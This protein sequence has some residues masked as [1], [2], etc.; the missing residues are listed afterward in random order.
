MILHL[1]INMWKSSIC[2]KNKP[3]GLFPMHMMVFIIAILVNSKQ[4][5]KLSFLL[6]FKDKI[7]VL[8]IYPIVEYMGMLLS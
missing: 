2:L 1:E 5:R 7:L 6:T 4:L 8:K 3:H